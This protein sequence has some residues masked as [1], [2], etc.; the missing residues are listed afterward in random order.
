[1]DMVARLIELHLANLVANET[2]SGVALAR[3]SWGS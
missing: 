3:W 1:M 2:Q